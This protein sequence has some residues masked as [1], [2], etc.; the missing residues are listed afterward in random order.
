MKIAP[1]PR[2]EVAR[3]Q[4]LDE[5]AILDTDAEESYA[6]IV[7]LAS[8]ICGTP[9]AIITFVDRDRQWFK[10]TTVPLPSELPRETSFCGHAILAD[11]VFVVEDAHED[12]R[13]HD[14]PL[15]TGAPYVRF[16]AGQRLLTPDGL[17][18]G[19]L[20]VIDSMPRQLTPAQ[21]DA[22]RTLGRQ[23]SSLLELRV[24]V[25]QLEHEVRDRTEAEGIAQAARLDAIEARE[26]AERA[27][28]AKSDF[29]AH[30]SHELRTPLNAIIGFSNVIRKNRDGRLS[31]ADQSFVERIST[32]GQHLLQLI[33]D[34]LDI[35]K[36]E[37]G[38]TELHLGA[39][40]LSDLVQET[41]AELQGR[42]VGDG[43]TSPVHLTGEVPPHVAAIESDRLR[44]KQILVNLV[45]NALKFTEQGRVV[46][47]VVT[48]SAG[49]PQR[50]DVTDTGIGIPANRIDAIFQVFEQG[51]VA[52][53][54]RYGG[55]G[56]GLAISRALAE[57]LGLRITVQSRVGAGSVFSLV[58]AAPR[59]L[60]VA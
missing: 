4:A 18:V 25:R 20:C 53:S 34:I 13:F 60:Q 50:I 1:I 28:R 21:H 48:D 14:N 51:D 10:A 9:M 52:T 33:N 23:V 12:A 43:R 26:L 36:I 38:R 41:V 6:S 39:V 32:N 29:L 31:A 19:T 16:Y 54:Q 7:R 35:A 59:V 3:Q 58:L 57:Q 11:D 27:S 30:M 5:L 45:G 17:A 46:V 42:I 15:V 37:S 22:L 47:R 44:L 24:R 8:Y 40:S 56:L 49:H 55:T 2:N